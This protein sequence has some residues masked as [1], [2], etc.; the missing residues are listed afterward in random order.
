M[1]IYRGWINQPSS[2]Q[3]LHKLHAKKCIVIDKKQVCVDI[4][5]TEGDVISMR[6][7]RV[8]ISKENK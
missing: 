6:V 4:Y 2:L 8:C 3:Q 1:E 7:P 5:F